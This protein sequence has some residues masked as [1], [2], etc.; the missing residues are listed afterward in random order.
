[1]DTTLKEIISISG[2][3]GLFKIVSQ[4][5]KGVIVE[6]IADGSRMT[7]PITSKVTALTD[8]S[9]FTN[10][11]DMP[12]SEVLKL[13]RNLEDA[14]PALNPKTSSDKTIR[15]YFEKVLPDFDRERVYTSDIKKILGWYNQLQASNLLAILDAEEAKPEEAKEPGDDAENAES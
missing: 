10:S 13:I 2:Y 7:A 15:D 5:R 4:G 6:S 12:L 14:K 1:M 11:T 9:V 3:S 8:I